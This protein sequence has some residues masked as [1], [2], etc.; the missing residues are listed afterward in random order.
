MKNESVLHSVPGL[1]IFVIQAEDLQHINYTGY[2]AFSVGQQRGNSG[3]ATI[4]AT[5]H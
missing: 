2:N 4:S 5:A 1:F 3:S